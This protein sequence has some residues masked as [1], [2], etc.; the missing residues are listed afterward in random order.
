M[1]GKKA[2]NLRQHRQHSGRRCGT[3]K[4]RWTE[5][6]DE[7]SRRRLAD[8]VGGLPVPRT[9][10]IGTGEGG[11]HR[12]AQAGGVD[13]TATFEVGKDQS[14]GR[15]DTSGGIGIVKHAGLLK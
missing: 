10:G 4:H 8:V 7:Q 9:A 14:R 2:R 13:T 1:G 3:R 5:F 6:A 12:R 15:N 11:F